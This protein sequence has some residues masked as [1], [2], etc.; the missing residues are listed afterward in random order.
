MLT[1]ECIE[2]IKE[3]QL[4]TVVGHYLSDLKKKGTNW[5]ACCPFHGEKS[6]SFKVNDIKGIY[7]CFGCGEAGGSI[8]F[9]MQHEKVNFYEACLAIADIDHIELEHEEHNYSE[10]QQQAFKIKQSAIAQQEEVLNFVIPVYQKNLFALEPDHP[11]KLWL[12]ERHIDDDTITLWNIGWGGDQWNSVSTP[13]VNKNLYE[14]AK[15]LG[16]TKRSQD[17]TSNFDGYRNRITFPMTDAKGKFIGMGGRYIKTSPADSREAPKWINPTE[18]EIYNKSTVLYGL[19]SAIQ[20]IKE[21]KFAYLVEGYTDVISPHRIGLT[22]T[23]ATCGTSF[24]AEQIKLIKKYTTHLVMMRD[25]DKAGQNSFSHSLPDLLKAGIKVEHANYPGNDPDEWVTKEL[26]RNGIQ[27]LDKPGQEDGVIYQVKKMWDEAAEDLHTK[28]TAKSEI[29]KLISYIGSEILRNNYLDSV[30]KLLKWKAPE[31][32]RQFLSIIDTVVAD[33]DLEDP[34][35]ETTKYPSWMSDEMKEAF[36]TCGYVPINRKHKG[37]PMV[38][39][40]AFSQN[41]KT[42]ISNFII[43]P[44]F[45]IEAGQESRYLSEMDNGYKK[46]VVD[47]PAKVFPSIEQFQGMCVSAGG[48]FMIYGS[49]NQWLRIVTDLL[50]QFPSCIEVTF[51]G[52][53][54]QGFFAWVDKAFIPEKGLFDYDKWGIIQHKEKNFLIPASSEAYKQ[55]QQFGN[56]PYENQRTLTLRQS[57][58]KYSDWAKQMQIVYKQKGTVGIAYTILTMFRDIIFNVDNNCPH[59]YGF[60]EPSSGKSKWAESISAVFYYKRAAFNLNSGTDFAFFLYM[61]QFSNCPAHLNEFDIEVIKPEWFQAIKGAYDGEG[62]V[63]GKMGSKNSTEIQKIVST[64]VL[65]GQKLI[66]ADDNSVVT[67]SIIEPFSTE[68]YNEEQSREYVKLKDWESAGMSSMLE[69]LLQH[70]NLFEEKYKDQ[71]NDQ[72]SEW[73]KT[74]SSS[75]QLNQ[76][77]LQNYAHLCTCFKLIGEKIILPQ[78]AH[79]FTEYCYGQATR[80][81][82]FIRS[83][84]TLS[85]FWRTLE[86][87]ANQNQVED[88]WDYVVET[89]TNI[90]I[91]KNRTETFDQ[92]FDDPTKVLFVRINNI[93]K[94]FQ[95]A[96]RNRSGKEAM[97]L[98]N[99][100][101]YFSSRKYYVGSIKSKRFKRFTTVTDAHMKVSGQTHQQTIETKKD[102][103]FKNTSCYAFLYDDLEIDIT[104]NLAEEPEIAFELPKGKMEDLPFPPV[105]K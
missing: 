84:D 88:G 14:A 50:H 23:I 92:T 63:R 54:E 101:H 99:L 11:V 43:R 81:S 22:N 95:Q 79:E 64:L 21:K 82:S 87:L 48:S 29:L 26:N 49:R 40:Y 71:F 93:H 61:S 46:V 51:L 27:C 91:T 31:T 5:E 65:T 36:L 13:L 60:G 56:D 28:A 90:T 69:E 39:Y 62:R 86:F 77:I 42:E 10:E 24:T 1:H 32:K 85:E 55:L 100:L 53:Q 66:T 72:L 57:P 20:S 19:S 73:R 33:D 98:E 89:V 94:L 38:G 8:K 76:R 7:K 68:Q 105:E 52:W 83:S 3:V 74:K 47:M 6:P 25:N 96:Y 80:W 103:E 44:L 17:N 18:C 35:L 41:G 30:I 78:T 2:K 67:R 70:R 37:K 4:S 58:I 16:I 59:L 12:K 15:S 75:V 9:V 102:V 97:S 45:R 34:E 104:R